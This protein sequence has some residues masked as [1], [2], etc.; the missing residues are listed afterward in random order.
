MLKCKAKFW[1]DSGVAFERE[2]TAKNISELNHVALEIAKEN[3]TRYSLEE[4]K[5]IEDV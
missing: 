1:N 4:I 3:K 5:E 2:L